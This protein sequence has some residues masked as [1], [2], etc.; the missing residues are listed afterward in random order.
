MNSACAKD[1]ES[2]YLFAYCIGVFIA[3]KAVQGNYTV[4]VSLCYSIE[5]KTI[6][7]TRAY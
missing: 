3:D 5:F 4:D 2:V 7:L 1:C 6:F